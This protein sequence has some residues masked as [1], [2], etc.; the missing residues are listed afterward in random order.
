MNNICGIY[1]DNCINYGP[2]KYF[3]RRSKAPTL[4]TGRKSRFEQLTGQE[5]LQRE[6][7]REKNRILSKKLKEKRDKIYKDL[8]QEF[9]QLEQTNSHLNDSIQQLY[10]YKINLLNQI[11]LQN[12]FVH[13]D[14]SQNNQQ[15]F[16]DFFDQQMSIDSIFD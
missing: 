13:N 11:Q 3:Q 6:L 12:Q 2:I 15:I 1:S 9:V 7:R 8:L 4:S 10:S 16:D 5:F 14:Q